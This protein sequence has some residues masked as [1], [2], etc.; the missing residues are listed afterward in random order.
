[1]QKF[2]IWHKPSGI[3]ILQRYVLLLILNEK[4]N[5][6]FVKTELSLLQLLNLST[7]YILKIIFA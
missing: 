2:T 1:M 3:I 7:K 4:T 6:T 5:K